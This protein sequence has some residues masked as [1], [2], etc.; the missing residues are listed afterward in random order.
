MRQG[1]LRNEPEFLLLAST[2]HELQNRCI[3]IHITR[4]QGLQF[5]PKLFSDYVKVAGTTGVKTFQY[6][7]R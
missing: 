2:L 5:C 7:S 6:Q 3:R 1:H 4:K